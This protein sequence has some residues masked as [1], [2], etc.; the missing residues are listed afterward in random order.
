MKPSGQGLKGN[1]TWARFHAQVLLLLA[2][3]TSA[4]CRRFLRHAWCPLPASASWCLY[5]TPRVDVETIK[6]FPDSQWEP[7]PSLISYRQTRAKVWPPQHGRSLRPEEERPAKGNE[8]Q[9]PKWIQVNQPDE[10]CYYKVPCVHLF[11]FLD[12]CRTATTNGVILNSFHN[13]GIFNDPCE[14]A[15]YPTSRTRLPS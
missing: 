13:T 6:A 14:A 9:I 5:G 7:D 2:E 11:S 12:C 15:G 1:R 3:Q 4:P 8:D 10:C